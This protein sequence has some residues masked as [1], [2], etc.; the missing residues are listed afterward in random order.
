MK[1]AISLTDAKKFTRNF[2]DKKDSILAGEFKKAKSLPNCETFERAAF[3]E[4]LAQPGCTG[5]RIYLAMDDEL[6]IRMV[7]VGVN[8]NNEDML[9]KTDG[10][11]MAAATTATTTTDPDTGGKIIEQGTRCPEVCP[12]SSTL[13]S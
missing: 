13:N 7:I 11:F 6:L 9:P 8:E 2:R 1:H 4:V 12:P 3:D 5:L 10:L